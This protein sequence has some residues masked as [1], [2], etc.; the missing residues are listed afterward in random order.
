MV[1]ARNTALEVLI[2]L[3]RKRQTLDGI[4]DEFTPRTRGLSRRDRALFNAL[5]YG[6]LPGWTISLLIFQTHL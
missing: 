6:V 1:D 2:T 4:L 3:D 5:I